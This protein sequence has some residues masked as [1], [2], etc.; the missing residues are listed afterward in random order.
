MIF[1][2]YDEPPQ[3]N[4]NLYRVEVV[5]PSNF[6]P[7]S[8]TLNNNGI[9]NFSYNGILNCSL[10]K[11]LNVTFNA[12]DNQG[13]Y[14]VTTIPIIVRGNSNE[15]PIYDGYKTIKVIYVDGYQNS[16]R[17]INLGSIYVN[18]S[19]D[20]IRNS[21]TYSVIHSSN[22]QTFYT[23]QDSLIT[24]EILNPGFSTIRVN[25]TKPNRLSALS[26]INL[27]V[28]SVDSESVR[29]ASVIRIQGK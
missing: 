9:F 29:Q 19:F 17:N 23:L 20:C 7:I 12:S 14:Q 16:S 11:T 2:D 28:E 24:S 5:G 10:T 15:Y 27:E 3:N 25:V 22:G 21:R 26:I 8:P 1:E 4:T 13:N 6:I 18:D